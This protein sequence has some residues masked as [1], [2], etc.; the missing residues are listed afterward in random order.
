MRDELAVADDIER[1]AFGDE[2]ARRRADAGLGVAA[3]GPVPPTVE[4]RLETPFA[5]AE[6]LDLAKKL[7]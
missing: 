7:L 3:A 2:N 4:G 6:N 1:R 5:Y